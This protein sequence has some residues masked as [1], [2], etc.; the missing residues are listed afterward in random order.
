MIL[1][2]LDKNHLTEGERQMPAKTTTH[3][4]A[5]GIP[6]T[7]VRGGVK[8]FNLRVC[9]DGTVRLSVPAR[10][11]LAQA[12]EMVAK[13]ADWLA[14]R[15]GERQQRAEEPLPDKAAALALF[16]QVSE[17][18]YPLFADVLGG[19]RPELR[20]RD[21][22]SRWGVCAPGKRRIT[23]ALRL[24]ARPVEQVEYVVL[25]EYCHF[26]HPDHQAGFW[27][28]MTRLMPDCKERRQALRR[29]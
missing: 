3:R 19:M 17:R 15:L 4:T 14:A 27:A 1:F 13:H 7:L 26:V 28:L 21:M 23:L 20:V 11:T 16:T 18:Y 6:Y 10:A 24:A 9:T 25:H 29:G 2:L 5:A 12:D 8:N 22:K